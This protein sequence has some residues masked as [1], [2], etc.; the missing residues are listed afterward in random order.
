[1]RLASGVRKDKGQRAKAKGRGSGALAESMERMGYGLM[2][3]A[4]D[5]LEAL[6]GVPG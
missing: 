5:S 3:S 2:R 1:M 6:Q 4:F